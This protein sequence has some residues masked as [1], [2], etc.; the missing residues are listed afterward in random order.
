MIN[1]QNTIIWGNFNIPLVHEADQKYHY[2]DDLKEIQTT[3]FPL[4]KMLIPLRFC[5]FKRCIFSHAWGKCLGIEF[6]LDSFSVS[7]LYVS[8]SSHFYFVLV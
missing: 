4:L 7:I 8:L 1:K 3:E 6:Y 2:L 5:L